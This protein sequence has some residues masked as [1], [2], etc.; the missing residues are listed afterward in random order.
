MH[1]RAT[2]MLWILIAV[3]SLYAQQSRPEAQGEPLPPDWCRKLPRP[4]YEQLEKAPVQTDWFEVYRIRPGVFAIYEPRQYEEVISYLIVGNQRA[5]LFDTGMGIS[6]ISKVVG[7]LTKLPVTVLN[8]HTHFDH[9]G[10]NWR[11][12][13]VLGMDTAYTQ[14]HTAGA[15][16]EEVTEAVIPD[17]ICGKLPEGFKPENYSIPGF[18]LTGHVKDGSI[19]NLGD[20]RLEVVA[21]PGHT[22]D[23]ISLLDRENKL[24]FTGDTFYARGA[25]F[26]YV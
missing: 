4:G 7:Q 2:G 8:S 16:H 20:R 13:D 6:D 17:R 21:T 26:L 3:S 1:R 19:I 22:P 11:Y 18:R 14:R 5:L 15:I 12:K 24:L 9:I 10:N 25:I 23:S